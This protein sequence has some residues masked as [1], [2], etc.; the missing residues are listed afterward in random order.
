MNTMKFSEAIQEVLNNR[1]IAK[2]GWGDKSYWGQLLDGILVL[3][4]PDGNYHQW[5]V[6]EGDIAGDD[7]FVL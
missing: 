4:K 6:S 7:W 3:H 2:V 1:C 5:I